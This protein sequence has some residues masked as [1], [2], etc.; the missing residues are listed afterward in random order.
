MYLEAAWD[1]E[2][3]A[4]RNNVWSMI[5]HN[6]LL[7]L[8]QREK[9]LFKTVL[10]CDWYSDPLLLKDAVFIQRRGKSMVFAL[11][12]SYDKEVIIEGQ[13][14]LDKIFKKAEAVAVA[15]MSGNPNCEFVAEHPWG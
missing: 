1:K 3:D 13:E 7:T 12:E 2:G 15:R 9:G 10:P 11:A 4:E 8:L 14:I 5:I 6:Q